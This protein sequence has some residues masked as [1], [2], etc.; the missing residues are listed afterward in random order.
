MATLLGVPPGGLFVRLRRKRIMAVMSINGLSFIE[1]VYL[2]LFKAANFLVMVSDVS[3]SG[4]YILLVFLL[5]LVLIL[6]ILLV[7]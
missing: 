5:W 3:P 2:L 7:T 1:L 4:S 6:Y